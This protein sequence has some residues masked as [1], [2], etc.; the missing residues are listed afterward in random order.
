MSSIIIDDSDLSAVKYVGNG[1][2]KG[3]TSHENAGTVTSSTE[4]GDSFSVTFTGT[5]ITVFGTIDSTS[6]GVVTSYSV[7]GAPPQQFTSPAGSGDTYKQPFWQSPQLSAQQ[8][9]LVVTMIKVNP[10]PDQGE[11]TVWFDF[12]Q[13][14]AIS[15]TSNTPSGSSTSSPSTSSA[16]TLT[17][18][19]PPN[20]TS[21]NLPAASPTNKK[22]NIAPAVGGIVAAIALL[23]LFIIYLIVRR[24][25]R[26]FRHEVT[27]PPKPEIDASFTQTPGYMPLP[28]GN[29]QA[30]FAP[31]MNG[32]GL[33]TN[34]PSSYR[35]PPPSS[36]PRSSISPSNYSVP[37]GQSLLY[38][39]SEAHASSLAV[40]QRP[41]MSSAVSTSHPPTVNSRPSI[42][43]DT[44][45]TNPSL[46]MA[47]VPEP[48]QHVDSGLRVVN[49]PKPEELPPV[50][51][52]Q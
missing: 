37:A 2:T 19:N 28:L 49:V 20:E 29:S 31:T 25:R 38:Y 11:G 51:S 23:A 46:T 36:I 27:R 5:R 15:Q 47:W 26:N 17:P 12:F 16:L 30:N 6:Q 18:S 14:D 39:N 34:S 52:A 24:R 44:K 22:G 45:T 35:P 50:Y 43:K 32:T 3:G 13:V 41:S 10:V 4:V 8:H 7:D 21:S 9:N 40:N 48:I 1:W 33:Q 42:S